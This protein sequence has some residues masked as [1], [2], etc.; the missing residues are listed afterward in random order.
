MR[1]QQFTLDFGDAP[2]G[3]LA[4]PATGVP[5]A[6]PTCMNVGPW[7]WVQHR[8]FGAWLGPAFDFEA[9]GNAGNCP[10][11]TPNTYDMDECFADGD[12]GL[13][14]PE[15]YTIQG[16]VGAEVVTPCPG[17]SGTA[18]GTTCQTAV[19][20]VDVDIDVTNLMPNQTEGFVNVLVDWNGDG[21]WAGASTCA[22]PGDT[23]EHVLVNFPV[24]NGFSGPLSAL[25]PPPFV[26]GP[27]H[28][29]AWA[30]FTISEQPV[31]LAWRRGL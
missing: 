10:L 30:R 16:P 13:L 20:G 15:P 6:F 24:P 12:A 31:G 17:Y 3:A 1:I 21:Q 8:N 2:E 9:D 23:P 19:W 29:Y 5:G 4:Y 18:L 28:G 25:V 11:F 7:L 22:T 26:I 14:F 27:R